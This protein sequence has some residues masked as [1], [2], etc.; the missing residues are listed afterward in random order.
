[1][2]RVLGGLLLA[3]FTIAN[4]H[5]C[6]KDSPSEGV[7]SSAREGVAGRV[8]AVESSPEARVDA[9]IE[10]ANE[11]MDRLLKLV[12]VAIEEIDDPILQ[13][14][15]MLPF[16]IMDYNREHNPN[17]NG[18]RWLATNPTSVEDGRFFA[19]DELP[20][21][22]KDVAAAAYNLASKTLAL[23]PNFDPNNLLHLLV[24][25]HE[26]VHAV[27]DYEY[28]EKHGG[29]AALNNYFIFNQEGGV[30]MILPTEA[31]AHALEA[32]I[33]K[34]LRDKGVK[35]HPSD[36]QAGFLLRLLNDMSTLLDS[37]GGMK[38]GEVPSG[39]TE[40][41]KNYFYG[42]GVDKLYKIDPNSG[43]FILLER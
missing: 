41:I 43:D 2:K 36:S 35:F 18:P 14:K 27:Q 39:F 13:R 20:G 23:N 21:G 26:L 34:L 24:L 6:V 12:G 4:I 30:K 25:Y 11:G 15:L 32:V 19:F 17:T 9:L 1:M 31:E 42:S 16:A 38:N 3:G 10:K 22:L 29:K 28:R 37:H 8:A 33:F 7:V 5:D 40:F